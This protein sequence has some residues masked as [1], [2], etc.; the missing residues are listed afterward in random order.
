MGCAV[1]KHCHEAGATLLKNAGTEDGKDGAIQAIP[2][3]CVVATATY[4]TTYDEDINNTFDWITCPA[5]SAKSLL[6]YQDAGFVIASSHPGLA[7]TLILRRPKPAIHRFESVDCVYVGEGKVYLGD[8]RKSRN[9]IVRDVLSV[10]PA[11]ALRVHSIKLTL[12][13]EKYF[14]DDTEIAIRYFE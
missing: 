11:N 8:M 10:K 3:T 2:V 7:H 14:C 5:L 13:K 6:E 12:D 1:G 9:E 4:P